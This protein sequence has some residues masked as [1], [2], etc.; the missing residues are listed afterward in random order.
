MCAIMALAT[1]IVT[2]VGAVTDATAADV[3]HTLQTCAYTPDLYSLTDYKSTGSSTYKMN[4]EYCL[5]RFWK[6]KDSTCYCTNSE[7]ACYIY[8]GVPQNDC[9]YVLDYYNNIMTSAA[10]FDT[11]AMLASLAIFMLTTVSSCLKP[12][13]KAFTSKEAALGKN[14]PA[15]G[16]H[17]LAQG[18]DDDEEDQISMTMNPLARNNRNKF[19]QS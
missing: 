13:K 5:T 3:I 4:A 1:V 8:Y 17:G 16:T 15:P 6:S 10:A 9:S 18:D 14:R 12:T 7:S 11:L 19:A 2:L